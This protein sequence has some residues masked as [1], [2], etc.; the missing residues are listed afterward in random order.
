MNQVHIIYD[1]KTEDI[2][3]NDLIPEHRREQFGINTEMELS[4]KDI[5]GDQMKQALASHYDQ[6]LSEF[7]EL[8]VEFHKTGDITVRP[9]AVFG[10]IE[11]WT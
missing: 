1:G 8:I 9:N 7:G 2:D 11:T 10:V 6:P 4:S 3:L 5:T